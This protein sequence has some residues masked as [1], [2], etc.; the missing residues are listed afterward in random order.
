MNIVY[1]TIK[2][3]KDFMVAYHKI[4]ISDKPIGKNGLLKVFDHIASIQ[5]DPLNVVGRNSDLVL[6]ARIKEYKPSLLEEAL[7]KDRTLVDAWDKMMGIYQINDYPYFSL[8]REKKGE[9]AVKTLSYRLSLDALDY[10]DE[11]LDYINTNGAVYSSE[12]SLGQVKKHKWGNIKP[13]SATLDYLF[14]IGKLGIK[15]R[16][17]TQKKYDLM[18]NLFRDISL[19][20]S[21]FNSESEFINYHVL[22]RVRSMGIV[23]NK[24]SVSWSGYLISNKK[25]RTKSLN[26][27]LEE[28]Q[29]SKV[30]ITGIKE[31]FYVTTESLN[32]INYTIPTVSFIAPLDNLIWDRELIKRLFNFDYK[33]EVYTPVIKRK[34]GYYVLPV[35]YGSDFIA[36][37]EFELQRNSDPLIIKNWWWEEDTEITDSL[38]E[39][40]NKALLEFCKYLGASGM[41]NT[42]ILNK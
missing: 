5:Y 39:N 8:V 4:N 24:S 7:Y 17:N 18:T 10:V 2:E 20:K 35:L 29:L 21:P 34:Y 25:N 41:R 28:G 19:D 38:L 1:M 31:E 6:Q 15:E 14:Q 37:V 40:I 16:R 33:W 36:R 26:A 9:E 30:I 42:K 23:W 27:L 11:I 12:L 13:S 32:N 22:R 3:A